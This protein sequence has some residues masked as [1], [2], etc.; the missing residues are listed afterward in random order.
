MRVY[1]F[2]KLNKA[3]AMMFYYLAY[4]AQLELG[5][6]LQ[7]VGSVSKRS[8]VEWKN[9]YHDEYSNE[10]TKTSSIC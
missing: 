1:I 7:W 4:M 3:H 9:M 5:G 8:T 6:F 2:R 10:R